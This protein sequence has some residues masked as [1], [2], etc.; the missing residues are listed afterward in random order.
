MTLWR[1]A[2]RW[3]YSYFEPEVDASQ[4]PKFTNLIEIWQSKRNGRRVPAWKD[5]DFYDF[6][7]WHGKLSVYDI[8]YDPYGY[9]V[10]LSG[11]QIDEIYHRTM[12]GVTN[13]EMNDLAVHHEDADQFYEMA[14]RKLYIT[15]TIGP[16]NV[17]NLDYKEIEFFELPLSDDGIKATHTIEAAIPIRYDG[18]NA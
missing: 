3:R 17:R 1:E 6:K 18:R 16:L 9:T 15:N 13:I 5:F 8:S 2:D 14:C 11:V 10:R 7:G 12:K 4:F